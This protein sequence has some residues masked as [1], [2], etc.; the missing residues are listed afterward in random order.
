MSSV[1][2]IIL[3]ILLDRPLNPYELARQIDERSVS[4]ILKIS[5]PAVYKVCKRLARQGY[6]RG[7]AM[8]EGELPEKTVYSVTPKGKKHFQRLMEHFS[9]AALPMYFEFNSFLFH[10]ERIES[11]KA[12]EMLGNLQTE[13]LELQE[14]VIAHQKEEAARWS[15]APEAIVEQYSMVISA[16]VKWI[17]KTIRK[18]KELDR[19][20]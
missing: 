3:G 5:R 20:R 18:H 10:I 2:L 1:E 11:G 8:R 17:D 6:L 9:R 19:P 15:F 16:L 14:W 4:R 7:K 13:L 12:Q